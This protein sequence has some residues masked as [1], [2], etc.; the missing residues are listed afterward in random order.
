VV[1]SL[2][3]SA[4]P[5]GRYAPLNSECLSP[6]DPFPRPNTNRFVYTH[7]A[8][9]GLALRSRSRVASLPRATI[10]SGS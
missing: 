4:A 7:F 9:R 10:G 2:R 8:L 3:E 5:P 6:V 1:P